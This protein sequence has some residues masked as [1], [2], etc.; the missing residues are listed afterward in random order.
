MLEGL[1]VLS[2]LGSL[3][4]R[5]SRPVTLLNDTCAVLRAARKIHRERR[6]PGV[7]DYNLMDAFEGVKW[8]YPPLLILKYSRVD[9][10][11]RGL[12]SRIFCNK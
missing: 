2:I 11:G 1:L 5:H 4:Y 3:V 6:F 10:T 12:I 7:L 9:E 8:D